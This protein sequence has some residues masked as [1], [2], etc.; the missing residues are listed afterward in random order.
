[1][2]MDDEYGDLIRSEIADMKQVGG[3]AGWLDLG[4][5]GH[6]PLCR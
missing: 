2:P 4:G 3:R 6:Q 1:M 5:E